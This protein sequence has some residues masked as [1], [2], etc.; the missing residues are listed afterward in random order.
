MHCSSCSNN[1]PPE[2]ITTWT[3]SVS[4]SASQSELKPLFHV[5]LIHKHILMYQ[6]ESQWLLAWESVPKPVTHLLPSC[7]PTDP[8][9]TRKPSRTFFL[10]AVLS[11]KAFFMLWWCYNLGWYINKPCFYKSCTL[12]SPKIQPYLSCTAVDKQDTPP[13]SSS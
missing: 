10:P 6:I 5:S 2:T 3:Y 11:L 1:V 8:F 13:N 7:S 4:I 9:A 12:L